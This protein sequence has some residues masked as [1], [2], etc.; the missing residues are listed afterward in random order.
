[1]Y[2][3]DELIAAGLSGVYQ[4]CCFC[5]DLQPAVQHRA[6][7]ASWFTFFFLHSYIFKVLALEI[8][9]SALF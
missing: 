2:S 4:Q 6:V 9:S 5:S 8:S 1:M 3:R 7:G